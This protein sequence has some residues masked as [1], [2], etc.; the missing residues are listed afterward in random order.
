MDAKTP[1]PG[2]RGLDE[3]TVP[4]EASDVLLSNL[5]AEA[6]AQI[7]MAAADLALIIEN[8]VIRD[9]AVGNSEL[10]RE[11][12][13]KHWREKPWIETV[14]VESRSKIE[15]LLSPHGASVRWREVNHPSD[16]ALDLPIKYTAVKI[17]PDDR[18]VALGRDL[19]AISN[20]QQRL[21]EAHQAMERDYA[22]LREAEARYKMLFEAASEAV[23]IVNA[24]T[25]VIED[26]NSAAA[27]VL[28]ATSQKIE[29][30]NLADFVHS[31]D[32]RAMDVMFVEASRTGASS[33][34]DVRLLPSQPARLS[35]SAFRRDR[36]MLMIVRIH[37]DRAADAVSGPRKS[38]LSAL[39]H[40]P[41]GLVIVDKSQR[42]IA[43]NA[44][45]KV[46]ANVS[47]D[48]QLKGTE[49]QACLGRSATDLN[50][51]F[52]TLK[53]HGIIRN[54][55]TVMRADFGSDEPVEVSAVIAPSDD[56]DLYALSVRSVARRLSAT[57]SL[58]EQ[59]P[60]TASQ[61]TELV[62]RVPLKDIVRDSTVLIEKLCIEAALEI[63]DNNRASAAE[64]LG[65]S[66]QGLYSKIK[67][68]G[69]DVGI[70][71][72]DLDDDL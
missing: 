35:A 57:P 37:V 42:L 32:H 28:G 24:R 11:E 67:R 23:M 70:G 60:N 50:V 15:E 22:R 48:Q 69:L 59:L 19:R 27:A 20:L 1:V 41:D 53:K 45:F 38:L 17:G 63:T 46:L 33:T 10:M 54:F 64:M 16:S 49:L 61:F 52:S 39:E 66:R 29:G 72:G 40:L 47:S 62:G 9:V 2:Q 34:V 58:G 31:D 12:L 56:G 55:A 43:S 14:T 68:S 26:V 21:V 25:L 5:D 51:L 65:L 6:T 4:F 44:A 36:A 7:V 3:L 8:G 30:A 13:H 18:Y 71:R